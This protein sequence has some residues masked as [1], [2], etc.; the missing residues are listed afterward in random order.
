M[1]LL[2]KAIAIASKAFIDKTDKGGNPYILHC[3]HVMEAV[4]D[5]G[6]EAMIAAVLHDLVEDT[7][8]TF[9]DVKYEG[10][11]PEVI[12]I[13]TLLTHSKHGDYMEYV[14]KLS[15]SETARAI[16]MADLRHN[17]DI[18]RMKGLTEKDFDRLKKYHE[19]YAFL[20]SL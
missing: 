10:F 20:K 2:G 3:L 12:S 1:K 5:L 19:A 18:N 13:I 11:S 8:W 9:E 17:S 14:R 6:E 7:E 4:S 15:V 16:K